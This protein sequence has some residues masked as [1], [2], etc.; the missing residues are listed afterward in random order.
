MGKISKKN[1]LD[2]DLKDRFCTKCGAIAFGDPKT[3]SM[4]R[5]S[6]FVFKCWKCDSQWKAESC[7]VVKA[8]KD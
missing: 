8:D 1:K 6:Y 3:C 5:R 7:K 2:C 4:N